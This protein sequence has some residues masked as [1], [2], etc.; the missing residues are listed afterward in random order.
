MHTV[1]NRNID[2]ALLVTDIKAWGRELGFQQIGIA[3]VEL[4]EAEAHQQGG[5]WRSDRPER[6]SRFHTRRTA[7]AQEVSDERVFFRHCRLGDEMSAD[8]RVNRP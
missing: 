8:L 4:S 7:G 6:G 3:N 5:T 1:Q 2:L